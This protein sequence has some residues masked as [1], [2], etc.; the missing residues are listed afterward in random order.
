MYSSDM[1]SPALQSGDVGAGGHRALIRWSPLATVAGLVAAY[2]VLLIVRSPTQSSTLIDG[3]GVA[4]VEIA[5][6]LL[7]VS[8]A[9]GQGRDWPV[10]VLLG[11]AVVCWGFGDSVFTAL[12]LG[13]ASVPSPSAADAFYVCFFPFAYVAL[14]LYARGHTRR[15]TKA[16]WLDGAIAGLGAGAVCAAFVF[17]SVMRT[18]HGSTFGTAVNLAYPVGDVLLLLL[19]AGGAAVT[20]GRRLPW[21][22]LAV[23]FTANVF[24]DASNLLQSTTH[25]GVV[26]N[27]AAWP[28]SSLLV[29][30]AMWLSPSVPDPL[31]APKPAGFMMPALAALAGLVVLLLGTLTPI[32]HFATA[33]AAATLLTVVLRTTLSVRAL[34]TQT[35]VHQEH[36]V[37]DHLTGLGNRRRMF[38]ALE[39]CFAAPADERP[40]L[41][42]LFIDLNGFKQVNDS[43]GHG[44]GDEAL[45]RVGARLEGSL[46][47]GDLLVRV[48]GDEFGA[49]L[50]GAG[51]AEATAAAE[52]IGDSLSKPLTINTVTAEIGASI[53]I[54]IA[55]QDAADAP[56]LLERADAAMY[57]AKRDGTPFAFFQL[58]LD[59]GATRLRLADELSAAIDADQLLLH[60]QPQL[61]LREDRLTTV[62]ALVRWRHP[63]HGLIPPM[64]FL[65]LADEAGLMGKL[66]RWVLATALRQCAAWHEAGRPLQMSVNVSV[67]DLLEPSFPAYVAALL[68]TERL[69][70]NCLTLEITETSIID[71]FDRAQ[72]AVGRLR[73]LGV[74]VSVDDFGSGFTSLAYLSDLAVAEM[75]LD[76]RFISP[77]TGD[78]S[79][80]ESELVRATIALGHALGLRVVAEGVEDPRTVEL[81]RSLGC[82]LVQGFGIA[83]PVPAAELPLA[84]HDQALARPANLVHFRR[85][86][87][88]T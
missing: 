31:A 27:G 33:L 78:C 25:F 83:R 32:D 6:G 49:V 22:L 11:T 12:S 41:A 82:D 86:A 58:E 1:R 56:S 9:R 2:V 68:A 48:G 59:H 57:R 53:G 10:A 64:Q 18:T 23:A 54:A 3:W 87:V 34:R 88:R 75:K 42:F 16:N 63:E 39:A 13:G 47:P 36:S 52:R 20:S 77:L 80:R 79:S 19:V 43:F 14:V 5:T 46:R 21:L 66:T 37:T 61:D 4:A 45:Q 35:R 26:L 72:R 74:A 15:L 76:R 44:V 60:Y 29:A 40:A 71:E 65:P 67:A 7:C 73:D 30:S 84:P 55:P 28:V 62:E 69:A 50:I 81:L 51:A 70:A 85:S 38:D 8:A 24:G 17:S